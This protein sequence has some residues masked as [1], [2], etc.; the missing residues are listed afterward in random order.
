MTFDLWKTEIPWDFY[1]CGN[2]LMWWASGIDDV[3]FE[4][5]DFRG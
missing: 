3:K 2:G 1:E 4:P 5:E